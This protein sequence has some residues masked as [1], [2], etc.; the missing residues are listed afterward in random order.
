M[1]R[2]SRREP[3][4]VTASACTHRS[5]YQ[6]AVERSDAVAP[7]FTATVLTA[8]PDAETRALYRDAFA[9]AGCDVVEGRRCFVA[10]G[11]PRLITQRPADRCGARQHPHD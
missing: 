6:S 2:Q 1:D 9:R 4:P 10:I 11:R 7:S 8:D 5:Q 3:P